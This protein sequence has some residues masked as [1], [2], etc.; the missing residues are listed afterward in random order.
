MKKY[1]EYEYASISMS[2]D[3]LFLETIEELFNKIG[4]GAI[5]ESGTFLGLGSTRVLAEQVVKSKQENIEFYTLEIDEYIYLQ[6]RKNLKKYPFVKPVYGIS[7]PVK[8]AISFIDNDDCISN[9]QN[10]KDVYIDDLENPRAFYINEI[11][12]KL[13]GVKLG[14][15]GKLKRWV[16]LGFAS[17]FQENIFQSIL[18]KI[19]HKKPL[20]LLDSCG[21]T[22]YL[23]FLNII[24]HM[25]QL[26]FSIIL[27]DVHHLKHFRS[28]AYLRDPQNGFTILAENIEKGWVIATK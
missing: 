5:L 7:V 28:L 9:H 4:V 19:K 18:P 8:E 21:G 14:F 16:K 23:E 25:E 13:S 12:G 1:S 24:K 10:Y 2:K 17:K 27:D 22:G 6:A 20:I 3:P 11:Q 26:P 15:L